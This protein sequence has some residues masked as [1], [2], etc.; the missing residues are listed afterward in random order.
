MSVQTTTAAAPAVTAA[1]ERSAV[2]P[3]GEILRDIA[4]GGIASLVVGLLVAGLGGRV[5]MRL[6]AIL[7]PDAVG[8]FTENGNRIGDVTLSGS[9]G[10]ILAG[11]FLGPFAGVVWVVVSPWIPGAGLARAILTVPIAVAL[12]T[13]VLIRADNRDFR[14]LDHDP[15]VVAVLLGL[16]AIV[17]LSIALVDGWLDRRMPQAAPAP[18]RATSVYAVLTSV[19]AILVFPIVVV[20]YFEPELRLAGLALV[21]VGLSTLSGWVLR[22]NGQ[23]RPPKRLTIVGRSALLVAVALGFAA[24]I[25]EVS[26]ALGMT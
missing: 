17:G 4:R 23:A 10:L 2:S 3:V 7:V 6:A 22:R 15:A 1:G 20:S 26:G 24:T 18:S 21:V 5:V 19:G 13:L 14:I 16:V 9:L 11:L 12:G 8:A 25:P